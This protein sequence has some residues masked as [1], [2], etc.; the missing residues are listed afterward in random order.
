VG[1]F[2]LAVIALAA[3]FAPLLAPYDPIKIRPTEA[4]T[5]PSLAHPFGTDQY[6]RDILS[7]A[8]TGARLSLM[9]GL[10]AVVVALTAGVVV[11][12]A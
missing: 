9:T 4:L 11:G 2:V 12:L 3:L 1:I 5:P 6:G 8:M 7:R 10:G